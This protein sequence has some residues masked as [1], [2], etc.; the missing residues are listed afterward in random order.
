MSPV[1]KKGSPGN[2]PALRN[3]LTEQLFLLLHVT[4]SGTSILRSLHKYK[5]IARRELESTPR[6]NNYYSSSTTTRL[7]FCTPQSNATQLL[8]HRPDPVPHN[9]PAFC[10]AHTHTYQKHG[11]RTTNFDVSRV[12]LHSLR[13][14]GTQAR[15][16][17]SSH[18]CQ[19]GSPSGPQRNF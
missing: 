3:A 8:H 16:T 18:G 1:P 11:L 9:T 6:H 2:I 17:G 7:V 10:A 5:D 19:D 14:D 4:A 15:P 12:V 13:R